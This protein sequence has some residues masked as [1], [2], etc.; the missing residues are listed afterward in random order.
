M[1]AAACC[2]GGLSLPG[3]VTGDDRGQLSLSLAASDVSAEALPGGE[4]I[5]RGLGDREWRQSVRLDAAWLLTDRWQA[6]IAVPVVRRSRSRAGGSADSAGLGDVAATVAY[7]ALPEWSYSSWRPRALVFLQAS[8]PT[9][10]SP[11]ESVAQYRVD[12][13]GTGFFSLGAGA[14]VMK[15]GRSW[16]WSLTA[17]GHRALSRRVLVA[18][19]PVDARPGWGSSVGLAGGWS[20]GAGPVRLGASLAAKWDEATQL[21]LEDL[22]PASGRA[23]YALGLHVSYLPTPDVTVSVALSDE[24]LL[25]GSNVALGRGVVVLV[26]HRWAR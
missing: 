19:E 13:R 26:Q 1:F 16:D 6:G 17:E 11:Y 9:G 24:T 8:L 15:S 5:A 25:G 21:A 20:P 4:R 3:L 7:E 2:G 22:P 12:V 14:A 23:G 18:D 10:I